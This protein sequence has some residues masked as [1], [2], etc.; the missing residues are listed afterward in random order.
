[1]GHSLEVFVPYRGSGDVF[2]CEATVDLCT[3]DLAV[4]GGVIETTQP[5][6]VK[7]ISGVLE[8]R[9][10]FVKGLEAYL[11]DGL[12]FL[13]G[14]G[15]E[16]SVDLVESQAGLLQHADED[17]PPECL[18]SI[19]ALTGM[20]GVGAEQALAFVVPDGGGGDVGPFSHLADSE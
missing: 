11:R 10:L 8:L 13:Y 15:A 5:G 16:N 1:V 6:G 14:S 2:S 4:G 20:P 18:S 7:E 3:H 17:E 12:P 19:A 9:D